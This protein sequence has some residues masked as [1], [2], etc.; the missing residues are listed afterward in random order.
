LQNSNKNLL[1]HYIDFGVHE[2]KSPSPFFDSVFYRERYKLATSADPFVH[3]LTVGIAANYQPCKWFDPKFYQQQY[4]NTGDNVLSQ[5]KHFQDIGRRQGFYPNGELFALH[6]K[7]LLSIIVPVYNVSSFHLNNCIRSVVNQSYPFW[8]ICLV[9]DCS[10]R[11]HVRPL[12]EEWEVKD[13]RIKLGYLKKN[14]G[15]SMASNQ[16]VSLATGEYLGFLD[17]DDELAVDCLSTLV[18]AINSEKAELYYTDE[19]LIGE[20][21]SRFAV[22]NKP[23][24]NPELLLCHNYITHF[25]LAKTTLFEK[26]GGFDSE[27]DGAQDFDLLLKMS[28]KAGKTVHIPEVLYHWRA[29]ES[30]TS[31]NHDEKQYADEAGREAVENALAR[32]KIRADVALTEW[33]FFYRI[34][35]ARCNDPMV[36][37]II[38]HRRDGGFEAWLSELLSLTNYSNIEYLIVAVTEEDVDQLKQFSDFPEGNVQFLLNTENDSR[39]VRYNKAAN[40][41]SGQYLVFLNSWIHLKTTDWVEA[42]LEYAMAEN[43]AVVGGRVLPYQENDIVTSVPDLEQKSDL[44]YARFL[45]RC[46]QHMNGLQCVQNVIALSWDL[47]MVKH[48][49]FFALDGFAEESLGSLFADSDLCL[50]MRARGYVNIYTPFALGKWLRDEENLPLPLPSI[51]SAEKVFFQNRWQN[52]LRMGDPYYNYGLLEQEGINR[53]TFQ[54]WYSGWTVAK[55]NL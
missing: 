43:S 50:R 16:A 15:I 21:G 12:L 38:L 11:K 27:K 4:L 17:N 26:V 10:S 44:Y 51:T 23:G 45:Q 24:F 8:E 2:G 31:I 32:R 28:E 1:I 3:Y 40:R 5:L 18:Q 37:V 19:D 53:D 46:S 14:G 13:S 39:A 33:K 29:S 22:F 49:R 55:E 25:V 41:S 42:M 48:G 6:E 20:D 7:P 9:D 47:A 34:K 35:K 30:S 52:I 36:S 54:Q